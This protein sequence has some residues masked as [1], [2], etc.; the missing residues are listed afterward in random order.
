MG[1]IIIFTAIILFIAFPSLFFKIY[2]GLAIALVVFLIGIFLG[3]IGLWAFNDASI[4]FTKIF[5][6]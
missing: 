2:H 1:G 6:N 5:G 4:F 3:L